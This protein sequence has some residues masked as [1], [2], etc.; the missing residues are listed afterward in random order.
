MTDPFQ[1]LKDENTVLDNRCSRQASII[2]TLHKQVKDL[3]EKKEAIPYVYC[4]F[5]MPFK[6][7]CNIIFNA[8]KNI[9]EEEPYGWRVIRADSEQRG[10]TISSN[11]E[12]HI[13]NSDC[14]VADVS[15]MNPNVFLEIGRMSY[16]KK[17]NDVTSN[18]YRPI[19]YLCCEDKR[20][21]IPSD[22]SGYIFY[23]YASS[24]STSLMCISK[25]IRQ[26]L[27]SDSS[28]KTIREKKKKEIYLSPDLLVRHNIC[29]LEMASRIADE[30][31]TVESFRRVD[32]S[33]IAENL[34]LPSQSIPT[35]FEII[36]Y[37]EDHFRLPSRR[38]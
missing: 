4:F 32:P 38:L 9:L 29:D 33:K 18:Y 35:I 23:T 12:S 24:S 17:G 1:K 15:E 10:L 5:A 36:H 31:K 13:T 37:L 19:I 21:N 22:L 34:N 11:V 3:E 27:G 16:Y 25:E 20:D 26:K 28:L 6:E 30:Y 7:E 14:Y 8:V 2:Q